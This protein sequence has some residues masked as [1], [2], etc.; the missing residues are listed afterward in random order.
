MSLLR[1]T[2]LALLFVAGP[3][4]AAPPPGKV[5]RIG[6]LSTSGLRLAEMKAA[7]AERGYVEGRNVVY[8]ARWGDLA[9]RDDLA[10]EVVA[11]RPDVIFGITTP[12]VTALQ[13]AT[14]T[15]P[16]VMMYVSDPVG[17]GF[18]QSLARPGG[19]VTGA[20]DLQD[21]TLGK[22]LELSL[23]WA[24]GRRVG[25]LISSDNP[26]HAPEMA[27]LQSAA[28]KLRSQ[29]TAYPSRD[30]EHLDAA[31]AAAARDGVRV[32]IVPGGAPFDTRLQLVLDAAGRHRI[33]TAHIRARSVTG[34]AL[35]SYGLEHKAYVQ[36]V[37]SAIDKVLNGGQ[38]ALM[39]IT[40]PTQFELTI[41][42]KTAQQLGLTI[43]PALSITAVMVE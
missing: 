39:P 25:V 30:I 37:A 11:S 10:A 2:F 4:L 18:A 12:V 42:S 34:G 9:K 32:M 38:P 26:R 22:L 33:G 3:S 8:E 29:V 19:N 13:R 36:D 5:V 35:F 41:N 24:P 1:A 6:Y 15:I 14:R 17:S 16:I 27:L 7:L 40:Q 43:P 23:A 21:A 31:F 20:S 28:Q